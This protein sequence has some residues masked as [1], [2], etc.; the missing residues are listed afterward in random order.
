M[1]EL[2]T[3]ELQGNRDLTGLWRHIPYVS[4]YHHAMRMFVDRQ[5]RCRLRGATYAEVNVHLLS[6]WTKKPVGAPRKPER[7][8]KGRKIQ[9]EQPAE[10]GGFL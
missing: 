6:E 8:A 3:R 4:L 5:S 7:G 2:S 9:K 1:V 10:R